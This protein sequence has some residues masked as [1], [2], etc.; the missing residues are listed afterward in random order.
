VS[1][2]FREEQACKWFRKGSVSSSTQRR[3]SNLTRVTE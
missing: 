1:F 3:P 2:R